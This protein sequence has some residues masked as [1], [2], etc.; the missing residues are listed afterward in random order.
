MTRAVHM[1][2]L[3]IHIFTH[4]PHQHLNS[5]HE[6]IYGCTTRIYFEKYL[7]RWLSHCCA[8][9]VSVCSH[10][11]RCNRR[12]SKTVSY[13]LSWGKKVCVD[14]TLNQWFA[15]LLTLLSWPPPPSNYFCCYFINCNFNCYEL[16]SVLS[17]DLRWPCERVNWPSKGSPPT[18]WE[19]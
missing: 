18:S 7:L 10:P 12:H 3:Q 14:H 19:L 13:A 9:I 2:F 4:E 17:S 1:S 16:Q 5:T 6:D 15:T 11:R 8:N